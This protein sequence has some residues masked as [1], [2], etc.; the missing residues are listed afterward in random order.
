MVKCDKCSRTLANSVYHVG[1][2][3]LCPICVLGKE[4]EQ[5]KYWETSKEKNA[6][7]PEGFRYPD[8]TAKYAYNWNAVLK[9]WVDKDGKTREDKAA[10]VQV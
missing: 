6:G 8:D 3:V 1:D 5:S 10:E 4:G 2:K 9:K 7:K